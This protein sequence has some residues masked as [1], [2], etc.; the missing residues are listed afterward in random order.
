[1]FSTFL[2]LTG[3]LRSLFATYDSAGIILATV[4]NKTMMLY[5]LS[6]NSVSELVA[7]SSGKIL[8]YTTYFKSHFESFF[9]QLQWFIYQYVQTFLDNMNNWYHVS[10]VSYFLF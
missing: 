3:K 6:E 2:Q 4:E 9:T 10:H 1:M 8:A 5:L 7:Y